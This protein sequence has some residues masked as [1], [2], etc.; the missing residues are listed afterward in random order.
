MPPGLQRREQDAQRDE[1]GAEGS[2]AL[3]AHYGFKRLLGMDI[4]GTTT[5]LS[6]VDGGAVRTDRRGRIEGVSTSLPLC[7]IGG[8]TAERAP[9]LVEAGADLIAAVEGVFGATDLEAAARAYARAF[10]A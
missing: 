1:G 3:A 4:G 5:D 10:G 8:I 7:A 2:R 6:L 9:A